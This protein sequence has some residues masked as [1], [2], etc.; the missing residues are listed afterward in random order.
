MHGVLLDSVIF[1]KV[2][3]RLWEI[4]PDVY[5]LDIILS[6]PSFFVAEFGCMSRYHTKCIFPNGRTKFGFAGNSTSTYRTAVYTVSYW[7]L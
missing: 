1:A 5:T 4:N 2:V 3:Q 7:I 6:P